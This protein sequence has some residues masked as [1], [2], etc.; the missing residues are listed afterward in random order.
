MK[1][2]YK[3]K[4]KNV[5]ENGDGNFLLQFKDD[6]TGIDG[7]FDPG[8]NS[9]GLTIAGVSKSCV[10]LTEFFFKKIEEAGIATHFVSADIEKVQMVVKPAKIFGKGLE[11]ICRLKAVGSFFRRFGDYCTNGQD[12]D[13]LV[14]VTLKDDERGDPPITKDQLD[15]LGILLPEEYEILKD[16]TKKITG[17]I[18]TELAKKGMTLYDIKFEFGKVDGKIT[19]IDEISGGSM[20]VYKDGESVEPLEIPAVLF[21]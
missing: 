16:L 13:F 3:G 18:K 8:A 15:M 5:Y 4:T 1:L 21:N 12:L 2:I 6:V 11:V 17:I 14:E 10:R 20:R 7:K 9:I 19:L